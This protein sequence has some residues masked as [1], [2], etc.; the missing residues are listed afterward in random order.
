MD[1]AGKAVASCHMTPPASTL[2]NER[3]V[4]A[5]YIVT[6][7]KPEMLHVYRQVT[8]LTEWRPVVFCQ[9]REN[10]E[11]FPFEDVLIFPKPATHQ[12]RRF[13]QK[14]VLQKPIQIYASEATRLD[15]AMAESGAKLLHVYFGHI[16][17]HLLPL[18][19]RTK[20]PVV[21]S[22]HGADAQVDGDKPAHLAALKRVFELA[23]LI[24]V[25]SESLGECLKAAGCPAG[26]IRIQRTG[27]PMD[28]LLFQPRV[29]PADGKWR[30]VQAGRLI[31][32][33]G[34]ATS[35]RAFA[36]FAAVYPE[37]TLTIAGEGRM[38]ELIELAASLGIAGKIKFAGFLKE[39][40]LMALM[41]ESHLFLHPSEMG[42]DGDQEGVPNAVLEAM[43]VGI[44]V[45]ATRHGGI[46]EAIEDGVSGLLVTERDHK[47]MGEAMLALA[48][49]PVH[50]T[51]IAKTAAER[52]RQRFDLKNTVTQLE[53]YY[54]EASERNPHTN[55]PPHPSKAKDSS[56]IKMFF[57]TQLLGG[58]W[59]L[60][61]HLFLT[62]KGSDYALFLVFLPLVLS[63]FHK[64][65]EPDDHS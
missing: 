12:L 5:S 56:F 44:P 51:E 20:L 6:F 14:T 31:A 21:V 34:Y 25:R 57:I 39:P 19:E 50:Y 28:R 23:R 52:V 40:D 18:L 1:A 33:K 30:C 10:E 11:T 37:T 43:A 26:K 3:P 53:G 22:F 65:N 64:I 55:E 63:V 17:V 62:V 41:A 8:A 38:Q 13:W 32:K 46:P 59:L 2:K 4:V 61:A 58:C 7:L 35:L 49:D 45:I 48:K 42:A 54:A 24:L 60:L 36:K 47:A 29:P 16:G 27:L 15:E 9:K